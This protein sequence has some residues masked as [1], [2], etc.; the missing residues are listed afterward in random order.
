[1]ET[2]AGTGDDSFKNGPAKS[3]KFDGPKRVAAGIDGEIY[4]TESYTHLIRVIRGD[5]VSTFAGSSDHGA[6]NGSVNNARFKSP[7]G[8]SSIINT[9]LKAC[10]H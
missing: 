6:N 3:A 1:V 4:V 9:L 2:A 8:P 7:A 5:S 10:F